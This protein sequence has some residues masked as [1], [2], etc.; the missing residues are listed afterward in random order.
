MKFNFPFWATNISFHL[1]SKPLLLAAVE[2]AKPSSE[3]VA[4]HVA[5][6][7]GMHP[8]EKKLASHRLEFLPDR[9]RD[10]LALGRVGGGGCCTHTGLKDTHLCRCALSFQ[11]MEDNGI[12]DPSRS[13]QRDIILVGEQEG[14]PLEGAWWFSYLVTRILEA[15]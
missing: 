6:I 14:K 4:H 8:W 3:T 13:F 2:E 11:E 10:V 12:T 9:S 5:R 15:R 7:E 1:L